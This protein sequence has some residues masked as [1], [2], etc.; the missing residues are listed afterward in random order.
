MQLE[1]STD[2]APKKKA[3][4]IVTEED[5]KAC[6]K[7]FER[8]NAGHKNLRKAEYFSREIIKQLLEVDG[9]DGFRI[10]YGLAPEDEKGTIDHNKK[11]NLQPRLFLVP[12]HIG[13]DGLGRDI[14]F[15]GQAVDTTGEKDGEDDFGGAGE[16][17][18]CPNFCNP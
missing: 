13:E 3:G 1:K 7:N 2:G 16:G 15:K 8:A 17:R 12:V 9:C 6:R 14:K 4:R 10:Y 18:P 5:I 11:E